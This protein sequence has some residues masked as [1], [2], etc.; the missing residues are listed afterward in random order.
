MAQRSSDRWLRPEAAYCGVMRSTALSVCCAAALLAGCGSSSVAGV[1]ASVATNGGTTTTGVPWHVPVARSDVVA[2]AERV[3]GRNDGPH[4]VS[5]K[6]MTYG[7]FQRASAPGVI[8][9]ETPD[10]LQI[11]AVKVTGKLDVAMAG[12]EA[13]AIFTYDAH[14]GGVVG[15]TAGPARA[16]PTYWDSL[17]DHSP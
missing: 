13:W 7:D 2:K 3:A 1:D 16:T 6:L 5:A 9:P 10:S 17:P 11:W 8:T 12:P 14:G 15:V 4:V